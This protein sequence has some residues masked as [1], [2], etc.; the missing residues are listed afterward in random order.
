MEEVPPFSAEANAL[1]DELATTFSPEDALAVKEVE[2]TTNHDVKAVEYVLKQRFAQ[3]AELAKVP[4][5]RR[6][7]NSSCCSC[8]QRRHYSSCRWQRW[9]RARPWGALFCA[10]RDRYAASF[11]QSIS[12][13][14]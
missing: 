6:R 3:N 8:R 9:Q 12:I 4:P 13:V 1:L 7:P 2:R 10:P 11:G 5:Q 14:K